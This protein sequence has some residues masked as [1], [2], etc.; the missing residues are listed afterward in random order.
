VDCTFWKIQ[1]V[2]PYPAPGTGDLIG[3][4]QSVARVT[5]TSGL[6]LP[7]ALTF[8]PDEKLFISNWEFGPPAFGGR[9][10]FENISLMR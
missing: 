5:I 1:R 9:P 10:G 7:A 8:G 4:D 2:T 6:N 3:V